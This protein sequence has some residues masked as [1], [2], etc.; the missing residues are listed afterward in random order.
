MATLSPPRKI[1][2]ID[3]PTEAGTH[4]PGQVKATKALKEARLISKLQKL[5][6]KVSNFS[7]LDEEQHWLPTDTVNGVRSEEKTLTVM[8]KVA[9]A[10]S[11]AEASQRLLLVFRGRLF[12]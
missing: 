6:Y 8:R 4:W 11:S 3:V 10:V 1:I 7:A 9:N 12:Y 2:V 5:G